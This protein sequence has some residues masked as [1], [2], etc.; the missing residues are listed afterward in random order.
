MRQPPSEEYS[1][2]EYEGER[3]VMIKI[4]VVNIDV[5]H[6][7]VFS[8][9]LKKDGRAGCAAVYNDGFRGDDEVEEFIRNCNLD[10]RCSTVEELADYVDIGF[11]HG[12]N[13][14]RHLQYVQP[15]IERSKPVF[16][17]KPIVG[18]L[19]DCIKIERLANNGV[20]ILGSSSARYAEE[21]TKFNNLSQD[22]KGTV[23]NVFGTSGVDEFNYGIHIVEAIGGITGVG[24]VSCRF[25]GRGMTEGR[26]CE[27]F[28][29]KYENG[30]SAVYNTFQGA[31]QP[32]DFVVMTTKTTFQ[33]QIDICKIY[34]PMLDM[35]C[36]YMETGK[37]GFAPVEALTESVKIMLAGR[38]S[39]EMDGKEIK[40]S[41]IPPDDPGYDGYKFERE[42]AAKSQKIYPGG[43]QP[44][45]ISPPG[46]LR[47]R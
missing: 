15:F 22:E 4:G 13:W 37:N 20:V 26:I 25:A 43:E 38:I 39:R 32:F 33:F 16:I 5:S 31:W 24:A 17:D 12:C 2:G 21:I 18:N 47:P 1:P 35:I 42:Y 29:V 28:L 11:I 41:D 23:V 34:G 19:A 6:P 8:E 27:T 14:N 40:L 10:R 30:C 9:Y 45:G 46:S 44:R 3:T 36:D 7:K